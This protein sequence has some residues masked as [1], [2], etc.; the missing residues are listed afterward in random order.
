MMLPAILGARRID[1]IPRLHACAPWLGLLATVALVYAPTLNDPFAGDDY[2]VLAPVRALGGWELI[3][4]SVLL[5]DNI[6]YWR[7]LISPLYAL[8]V[9]GFGLRPALFHAV[10]LALHL[11]NVLLVG[12][13]AERLS[14][15]RSV[16]LLAGLLFGI[17]PAHTTTVAQISSTVELQ[18]VA[19]YLLAV[20]C[21]VLAVGAPGRSPTGTASGAGR[22]AQRWYAAA[23][24][25]F[26]LA[27]LTKESTASAAAVIAAVFFLLDPVPQGRLRRTVRSAAPY[28]ALVIPYTLFA[29]LANT[30]DPTGIARRLYAPGAHI[31]Q[32]LWWMAARLAAPFTNGHGPRVSLAG[33]LGAALLA[34]A[35]LLIA[36]RGSMAARLL[37]A[38]T[39]IALTPLTL[40]R[41]EMMLG[42]FTYQAAIPF[43]ILLGM[44]FGGCAAPWVRGRIAAALPA[45]A[46]PVVILFALLTPAQNRERTREALAYGAL[47]TRL[48]AT[49]PAPGPGAR[50]VVVGGPFSGPYHA[51]YLQAL[52]DTRFGANRMSLGWLPEGSVVPE[53]AAGIHWLGP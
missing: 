12:L 4:K 49:A 14:G 16:G 26:V 44:L 41:P 7:P 48:T 40:W 18:S 31:G 28:V 5:R 13:L 39:V 35:A 53:V 51:L 22:Q 19:F 20:L 47:D 23:L 45:L 1:A 33:H 38:W 34:I 42:R 52:A 15:R 8:E 25:C 36:L 21:A 46:V 11:V 6:P 43:S 50:V 29:Y 17:N 24:L 9:H 2:L 37:A 10:T 27:L 32:N 30:D 3:W